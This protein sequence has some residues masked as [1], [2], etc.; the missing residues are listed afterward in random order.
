MTLTKELDWIG[1]YYFMKKV[2]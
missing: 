2:L 1:R